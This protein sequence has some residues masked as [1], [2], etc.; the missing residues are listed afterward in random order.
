M[1]ESAARDVVLVRA[2]EAADDAQALLSAEDRRYASR[3]A[4]ELARWNAAEQRAPADAAR[5][6]AERARLLLEK[7]GTRQRGLRRLARA[8]AWR[9]WIGL[10]LPPA[11][12]VAGLLFDRLG[13]RGHVNVLA[14]P[15]LALILWNLAV[16]LL[17]LATPVLRAVRGSRHTAP[18]TGLRDWL[19]RLAL[20]AVPRADDLPGSAAARFAQDWLALS[21][22]LNAA[23]VARTLHLG[24]AL[25]AAGAVGGLYVRGLVYDYRAGW[26]STFLDAPAVHALLST[27]LGPAAQALGQTFPTV[28][29]I[30][31]LRFVP[32]APGESAAR[33]I[34]WYALTV[35]ALVIVPRL[36]LATLAALRA[37]RLARAF[38]L[39]LAAP[40]F[41]R[42]LGEFAAG[43]VRLGVLPY[44]FTLDA[45]ATQALQ[46]IAQRLFG[47]RAQLLLRPSIPFGEEARAAE[48]PGG[49]APALALALF[50]LAA[51]PEQENHGAFLDALATALTGPRAVLVDEGSY[52]RRLGSQAGAEARLDE[53]RAA[54]RAFA[55]SR[56]WRIAFADLGGP[57]LAQ[58]ERDLGAAL[59]QRP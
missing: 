41:H 4:A 18:G 19:Q 55:G 29:E 44:S 34:H 54:W 12:L 37:A 49:D 7:L 24:A 22:P 20:R 51:T 13:D 35:G 15:L 31:A 30:A 2:I 39:D 27:L 38:P 26:E 9:P 48:S 50:N 11:A 28:D 32:G 14:F 33:W 42:L 16:Y 46:A 45:Q 43:P 21:A 10:A 23:R 5:F 1:N 57:D 36:L 59:V 56:G 58:L 40:Y 52:R 8:L 17:L 53:R 25:F 3:A 47:D 6:L